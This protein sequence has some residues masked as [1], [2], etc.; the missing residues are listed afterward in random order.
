MSDNVL[1][2]QITELFLLFPEYIDDCHPAS[3]KYIHNMGY[4]DDE[5]PP[6]FVN[7][8]VKMLEFFTYERNLFKYY[9]KN[10]LDGMLYPYQELDYPNVCNI[11][12]TTLRDCDL[13]NWRDE[14]GEE[15]MSIEWHGLQIDNDTCSKVYERSQIDTPELLVHATLFVVEDA[16]E[17]DGRRFVFKHNNIDCSLS[18]CTTQRD[19]HAWLSVNRIPQR[20]YRY[21]KKH[22]ENGINDGTILP[23]GTLAAI[24]DCSGEHAQN[25]L[26]KAIGDTSI[27]N[28][29]WYYD[30]KFRKV[31][32]FEYQNENPQNE[33]HAYHLKRGDKGYE[34]V[35]IVSLRQIQDCLPNNM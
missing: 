5:N 25:L 22:G 14:L 23:D 18:Y 2:N 13:I 3:A 35:N 31:L 15:K 6:V 33:Y 9:D 8:M 11:V 4:P 34:K 20:R 12:R 1:Q 16:I 7:N 24:L 17:S 26:C 27:D 10:N 21:N 28:N 32:Y 19:L 30:E 29:L